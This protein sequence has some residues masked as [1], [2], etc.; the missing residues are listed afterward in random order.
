MSGRLAI[1]AGNGALP[2]LL[3]KAAPDALRF[4]FV[5]IPHQL[6][7]VTNEHCFEKLGYLFADLKAHGVGEVVFGGSM[8]R[9]PLDPAQFDEV[10]RKLAPRLLAAMQG[11]DDGL[12]RLVIQIFEE[13]GFIVRGA[14]EIAPQLTV[15]EGVFCGPP[16]SVAALTDADRAADILNA[17]SP[18]DVGQG[19]VVAGGLCLGIETIQGTDALLRFVNETPKYLRRNAKGVFVKAPKRGQDL[20]VDMPAIGPET[21]RNATAAGVEGIVLEAGGVLVLEREKVIQEAEKAGLF[22]MGRVL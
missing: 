5:G 22:I 15:S 20:R 11:G 2:V 10:M 12:L 9:P 17:L 14:H 18:V 6:R 16:P 4:S 7:D 1:L 13:Q 19:C 8:S 21:V 3:S